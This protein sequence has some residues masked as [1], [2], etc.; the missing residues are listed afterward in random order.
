MLAHDIVR[1]GKQITRWLAPQDN[2]GKIARRATVEQVC[3]IGLPG[4]ELA[5]AC[6][7]WRRESQVSG[8]SVNVERQARLG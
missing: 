2:T 4:S 6:P 8:H 5:Y 3:W 1:R 7:V